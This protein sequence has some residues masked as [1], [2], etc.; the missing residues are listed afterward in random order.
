MD[1]PRLTPEALKAVEEA[2]AKAKARAD[3]AKVAINSAKENANVR[4][5]LRY[6]FE[7]CGFRSNPASVTSQQD[8]AEKATIYN[9]GRLSVF[10][11]LRRLM[12]AETENI[13]E[14]REE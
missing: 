8:V 10:H 6:V 9:V 5:V 14:Q 2:R 12:S 13:I 11:D 3:A 7:L 4:L 1:T